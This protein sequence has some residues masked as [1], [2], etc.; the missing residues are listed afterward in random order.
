MRPDIYSLGST[1]LVLMD[2]ADA[3]DLTGQLPDGS[4]VEF[5][6][7]GPEAALAGINLLW[8]SDF[9]DEAVPFKSDAD[10]VTI[11]RDVGEE[12]TLENAHVA[13]ALLGD[14]V[15]SARIT[16]HDPEMGDMLPVAPGAR[17]IFSAM[18]AAHR[19]GASL[20][21]QYFGRDGEDKGQQV[22]ECKGLPVGGRQLDQYSLESIEGLVPEGA[23]FV[24][25]SFVVDD[26]D[27]S[28]GE[29]AYLFMAFARLYFS[30]SR[31]TRGWTERPSP[32]LGLV[33]GAFHDGR[34]LLRPSAALTRFGTD[35]ELTLQFEGEAVSKPIAL[36]AA[37]VQCDGMMLRGRRLNV[38]LYHPD[39][40]NLTDLYGDFKRPSAAG[41]QVI[42]DGEIDT[43]AFAHK[44]GRPDYRDL[45]VR[46]SPHLYDG[47]PHHILV[48]SLEGQVLAED[49]L[50]LSPHAM[51]LSAIKEHTRAPYKSQMSALS[52]LRYRSLEAQLAQADKLGVDGIAQ[53]G[54]CHS[55]VV[56]GFDRNTDFRP[57]TFPHLDAPK[58]SVIVPV[59]NKFAVTYNCL[60]ALLLAYNETVFELI[61]VDDGS[62]D[63]TVKL[64]DYAANVTIVRHEKA[65]GFVGACNAGAAAAR[66]EFLVFLNNDTEVTYRWLDEVMFTFQH[67]DGVGLVGSKLIYADGMLQEAGGIIWAEGAGWN[68]GRF[69]N[70]HEPKYNYV[71]PVHYCSGAAITVSREAWE[72][73]GGFAREFEPAYYEDTDLAFTLRAKG[74]KTLYNPLSVVV[75]FEGISNGTEVASSGLKR[76]QLIN[77]PKFA[78]KHADALAG[79]PDVGEDADLYKDAG[80]EKRV[81]FLDYQVPRTDYDAGSYAAIQEMRMMQALGYKVTFLPDNLAWLGKYVEQLQRIGVEVIYAP[82]Y[83]S[84][85]E[86]LQER[87]AEF[88]AVFITRYY[89]AQDNIAYVRKYA[90]QAKVLFNNA[91]LHF[92]REARA[93]VLSGDAE[94]IKAA[95]KTRKEELAVM[96]KVDLLLSYNEVEHAVVL[97]HNFEKTRVAKTPWVVDT[98][99]DIPAFDARSDIAFLGGY[100]HPPNVEAMQYFVRNVMPLLRKA[101]AGVKLYIYGSGLN[102]TVRALEADDVVVVGH[103]DDVAEVYEKHRVFVAPLLSGAG[104][105]GK[106][107]AA[108]AHGIPTVLSR[109]A[110]E[111]TG[112]RHGYDCEIAGDAE[113][114]AAS[115]M[116]LY[117]DKDYWAEVSSRSQAFIEENYA[118]KLACKGMR[119]ALSMVGAPYLESDDNLV[120]NSSTMMLDL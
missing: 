18:V 37:P 90:P 67:F 44:T 101:K 117:G 57:L 105:K 120:I 3:N 39:E 31:L 50:I 28:A 96:K 46:L 80:V 53:V 88:D 70:P 43:L 21:A 93:A 59:H 81:L 16:Y 71:R 84:T 2:H 11:G 19:C 35:T 56:L 62:S 98:T 119:D 102:D 27:A 1:V 51:D 82:F 114:W 106:V 25:L 92:L 23:A 49:M 38:L 65:K 116:R 63:E 115:V 34:V 95:K 10:G 75:H 33:K 45:Y 61:V 74:Y 14:G 12:W 118:F 55:A 113:E 30:P 15:P 17:F 77:Q 109:I 100:G 26:V 47:Q 91:D 87:G 52:G 76:F 5:E 24:R 94:A 54:F 86:F 8:N 20:T 41:A 108:M 42:V 6:R 13:Y 83:V 22:T 7:V 64:A 40:Q 97:S 107:L 104:I 110:A 60:A 79:A 99:K 111:G 29:G 68:Y 103:V 9:S 32:L 4:T 78:A 72:A 112:V 89:V 48:R 58:V 66:G 73:A 85:E 69:G 36:K